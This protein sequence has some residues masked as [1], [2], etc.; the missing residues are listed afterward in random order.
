MG[1]AIAV[2]ERLRAPG[3]GG[4]LARGTLWA[5][6]ITALGTLI[7][8]GVQVLLARNVG[9]HDYGV[10]ALTLAAMNIAMIV[11]KLDL[12]TAALRFIGEYRAR[13]EWS[14]LRGFL[15][16]SQQIVATASFAVATIAASIILVVPELPPDVR[17][18]YLAGCALLPISALLQLHSSF[19]RGLKEFVRAQ[20]PP[21][22]LRPLLLGVGIAIAAYAI[23]ANLH[24][25]HAVA[26]NLVAVGVALVVS[27]I[28]LR[29]ILP[30]ELDAARPAYAMSEWRSVA[31]GLLLISAS[32][33]VLSQQA[34]VVIVGALLDPTNAGH[35]GAASQLAM[36][37]QFAASAVFFV[38]TPMMA[39]LHASQSPAALQRLITMVDRA[40]LAISLPILL[41]LVLGG[42]LLL[43]LYS[44]TFVSAYPVLVILGLSQTITAVIGAGAGF[45]LSMTGR[46][47][48]AAMIIGSSALLNIVLALTLTP[49]FGIVGTASAT[50]VSTLVR[51]VVLVVVIRR[52]YGINATPLAALGTAAPER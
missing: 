5:F 6:I 35:Y 33:L 8:F 34:D 31:A 49:R 26:I 29:G 3:T 25:G 14:L 15:H 38:A 20:L 44:E 18:A 12:D 32:Q 7:S 42:K 46:Q 41:A 17:L 36:L 51:G 28:W 48:T 40:T 22:L 50:A 47:H 45:L 13:G 9:G 19:L 30:R 37:I 2:L 24:A 43:G 23:G 52:E 16:R 21:V 10:Y 27:R 1:A 39:E 11:G 4:V